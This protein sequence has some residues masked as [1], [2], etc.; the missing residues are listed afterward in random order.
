MS[1]QEKQIGLFLAL[2]FKSLK[3]LGEHQGPWTWPKQ[4]ENLSDWQRCHC[5]GQRKGVGWEEGRQRGCD[6]SRGAAS[7]REKGALCSALLSGQRPGE[8]K[9]RGG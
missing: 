2:V 4:R 9:G 1:E 5:S 6:Q 3:P 7:P 8:Q